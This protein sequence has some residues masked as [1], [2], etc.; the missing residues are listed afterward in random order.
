M[1]QSRL[2]IA[3]VY[4]GIERVQK[5]HQSQHWNCIDLEIL[6]RLFINQGS[7]PL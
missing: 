1:C 6:D 7:E 5:C 3:F 2:R 4:Y